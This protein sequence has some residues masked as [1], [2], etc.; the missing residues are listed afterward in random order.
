MLFGTDQRRPLH[1]PQHQSVHRD[2]R[3][4]LHRSRSSRCSSP[5]GYRFPSVE[6]SRSTWGRRESVSIP[7]SLILMIVLALVVHVF[8]SRTRIGRNIFAIGDNPIAA[9]LSGIDIEGTR[10]L[11]FT[12]CGLLAGLGGVLLAGNLASANPNLGSWLRTR[13]DRR[14]DTRRYCTIRRSRFG[15]GCRARRI[16]DGCPE[17]CIC[18]P[19]HVVSLASPDPGTRDHCGRGNGR[20]PTWA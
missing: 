20:D 6:A 19:W 13:C 3:H 9:R 18:V 14:R 2:T 7:V 11:V 5:T 10:M 16:P 12:L 1:P 15:P 8:A 4:A 17:E